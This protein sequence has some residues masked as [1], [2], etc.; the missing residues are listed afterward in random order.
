MD[1]VRI[2]FIGAGGVARRHARTLSSFEDVR[3]MA[4]ADPVAAQAE[5][6]A[7]LTGARAYTDYQ[8]ML[9]NGHI[10]ALYICVPPYAHGE[11]ERAAIAAG[12]P[13]LVEKPI[14]L[15]LATAE[16]IAKAVQAR[17]IIT[18]VGYHWRYL[19]T[20]DRAAALLN[21]GHPCRLAIGSWLDKIPDRPW[22][23]RRELSGGQVIEQTTH[24][25]D[26][27]RV[28]LGEVD[29]VYA[30][31]A[32]IERPSDLSVDID[33][34]TVA[35]LRFASGAVGVVTSTSLLRSLYRSSLELFAD[36]LRIELSETALVVDGGDSVEVFE[37]QGDARSR[38]D[39][40][41]VDAVR[42]RPNRIR[43][44]YLEAL[45]TQRL[46][47]AVTRSAAEGRPIRPHPG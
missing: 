27:A 38:P 39:R 16:S 45:E 6:L 10:D 23:G 31:A 43:V 5:T 14:A 37:A 30:T 44:P 46:G 8:D 19:D 35:T 34:A 1:A 22:W 47:W 21:E 4:V 36:G 25:L 28:L 11:P 24:I 3:V 13:F 2:A 12:L 7:S 42:G 18:C 40:D 33:D 17:G 29:E 20:L 41:F 26:L 9:A 32:R 15:D